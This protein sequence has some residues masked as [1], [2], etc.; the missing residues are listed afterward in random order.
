[1][2]NLKEDHLE[3][4]FRNHQ[5]SKMTQEMVFRK[6]NDKSKYLLLPIRPDLLMIEGQLLDTIHMYMELGDLEE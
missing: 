2:N 1:M 5:I 6:N 3:A 4:V